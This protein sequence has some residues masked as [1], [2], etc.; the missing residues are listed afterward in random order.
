MKRFNFIAGTAMALLVSCAEKAGSDFNSEVGSVVSDMVA[1]T[2][3]AAAADVEEVEDDV[4]VKTT[5]KSRKV[6]WEQS[7][8]ITVF[9]TGEEVSKSTFVVT[10]LSADRTTA[11]FSG[12]GDNTA[13]AYY[14]V[15]P[16][17]ETNSYA[18]GV[19]SVTIPSEQTAVSEGFA[20]G[21][22]VSVAVSLQGDENDFMFKNVGALIAFKFATVDEAINTKSVT[23]KARKS[24]TEFWGLTGNVSVTVDE[25]KLPLA[26]E[27]DV[28][29]VV[30]KAPADGFKSGIVYY[31]SV[32]PV[33][34]CLGMEV[35]FTD[36]NDDAVVKTNN[37]EFELLRSYMFNMG[38]VPFKYPA[39]LAD[40]SFTVDFTQGWPF[41]EACLAAESQSVYTSTTLGDSYTYTYGYT[42]DGVD[43][44]VNLEFKISRGGETSSYAYNAD[45]KYLE[46]A[47]VLT[48]KMA[49]AIQLPGIEGRY[50]TQVK[51]VKGINSG[52]FTLYNPTSKKT[53]DA[54]YQGSGANNT[55]VFDLYADKLI[56]SAG[57]ASK[58]TT[59]IKATSGKSFELRFRD[60]SMKLSKIILTYSSTQP[61][62]APTE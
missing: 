29:E 49:G 40:F 61:G 24:E 43:K 31:V 10:S 38:A 11:K 25:D 32:C 30:V 18:D 34:E 56:A 23:I 46:S 36:L 37:T 55:Y 3:S 52:R 15:Y 60:A 39:P 26:S 13:D 8:E 6:Y 12:L 16:H 42:A 48:D 47:T 53:H 19:L 1:M 44:S 33:G 58:S 45:K 59:D 57:A 28:E 17:A 62:N 5:Y 41:N 4:K 7:D 27:G 20:S 22:N 50:L 35:T 2:F 14:A 54:F 9:S 21:A 51:A